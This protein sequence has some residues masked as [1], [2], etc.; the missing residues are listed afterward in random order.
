MTPNRIWVATLVMRIQ[1][2]FLEAPAL[3][4]TLPEA[5]RRF[6]IDRRSCEAVLGALVDARVLARSADGRYTRFFPRL[7]DAA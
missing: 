2:A 4:L 3:H 7:A 6:A 5:E 1:G